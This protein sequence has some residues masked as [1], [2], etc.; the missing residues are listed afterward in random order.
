MH[1]ALI[2]DFSAGKSTF[3][4]ALLKQELLKTAWHATTA[5]PTL[6]Y[7]QEQEGIR[8]LVETQNGE[9]FMMDQPDQRGLLERKL[10]VRLP[11][12]EHEMI[13]LLS[14]SNE[15]AKGIKRIRVRVP[16]HEGL[17]YICIIDTPGVNPGAEEARAHI[18]RTQDILRGYAD[19]TVVLFQA[20]QVYSG[21]FKRFLEENAQCFLNEAVFVITMMD[22]ISPDQR[23]SLI[24]YVRNQLRQD[25]HMQ[26]PLV[27]G[28]CARAVFAQEPDAEE[29][30]WTDSFD[31]L[32]NGLIRYMAERRRGILYR[33]TA[34]LLERLLR[35]LDS[36]IV[37]RLNAIRR[38]KKLL[39]ENSI[40][41]M[42]REM[43][44]ACSRFQEEVGRVSR[45]IQAKREYD[46]LFEDI[47]SC[48]EAQINACTKIYGS[49][50]DSIPGYIRE[51]FPSD[52]EAEQRKF[53][54][55]IN[56]KLF[57]IGQAQKQYQ[58]SCEELFTRYRLGLCQSCH[59]RPKGQTS[60]VYMQGISMEQ[61][62]P[63]DAMDNILVL[64]GGITAASVVM[65]PCMAL[66]ALFDLDLADAVGE[67]VENAI[68]GVINF[69]GEFGALERNKAKTIE[70][71]RLALE[72]AKEDNRAAFFAQA[73]DAQRQ[74]LLAAAELKEKLETGYR[75]LYSKKYREY[76]EARKALED[77]QRFHEQ[78]QRK[79][80]ECLRE[81]GRKGRSYE[82]I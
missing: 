18:K 62:K 44:D 23:A 12:E 17:R 58:K 40:E 63:A 10:G 21:S 27:C 70:T 72:K 30:L 34:S 78:A 74:M 41:K 77:E 66:D 29:R 43:A 55:R 73:E 47:L 39:E 65:L 3:I 56:Q 33:Q 31:T 19:A 37:S 42:E 57:R 75:Q 50:R 61:I 15:L 26:E 35:E 2:G 38:Q 64:L 8:I 69:F 60:G 71:V 20:T 82:D 28:C 14:T 67:A 22:V 45:E 6:I 53:Q 7:H 54:N 16:S 11:S 52:V 13:A 9:K 32:R 25:F 68:G 36:E 81:F 49:G 80:Q 59:P 79:L 48:A 1:I 24:E 76:T 4:N 46:R 51:F 5:V